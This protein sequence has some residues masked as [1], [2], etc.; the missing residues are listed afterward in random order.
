[1]EEVI[2]LDIL[3][4]ID[5]CEFFGH[6]SRPIGVAVDTNSIN[7]EI[8]VLPPPFKGRIPTA[9]DINYC[10]IFLERVAGFNI[11]T[12]NRCLSS[13][14]VKSEQIPLE[15]IIKYILFYGVNFMITELKYLLQEDFNSFY[16]I[17]PLFIK[18]A[19]ITHPIS[20]EI[21]EFARTYAIMP[22]S[23]YVKPDV[24]FQSLTE[25]KLNKFKRDELRHDRYL[26]KVLVS[27]TCALCR[28]K[29][30]IKFFEFGTHFIKTICCN[31][32]IHVGFCKN[33][34]FENNRCKICNKHLIA[35]S[36]VEP[37]SELNRR[38]KLYKSN[39]FKDNDIYKGVNMLQFVYPKINL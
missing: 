39:V 32:S 22:L 17:L 24:F 12:D 26:E 8:D 21:I 25:R 9:K 31:S 36:Q 19:G 5:K 3:S 13:K 33:I 27:Q 35:S 20:I 16:Q 15:I 28:H 6:Y 29:D 2:E 4:L 10:K 37:D 14:F 34:N 38:M 30:V 18:Y 1:M 11:T 23:L 7:D